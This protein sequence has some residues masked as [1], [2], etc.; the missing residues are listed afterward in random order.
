MGKN[1]NETKQRE[2]WEKITRECDINESAKH[3]CYLC[4]EARID[5][6]TIMRKGFFT[7]TD[8]EESS[9]TF[10]QDNTIMHLLHRYMSYSELV[11]LNHLKIEKIK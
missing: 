6:D 5:K 9:S 2:D 11:I 3:C 7:Y 10:P 4:I 8:S 1:K